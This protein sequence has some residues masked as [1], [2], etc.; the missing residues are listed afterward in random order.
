MKTPEQ[1]I[2]ELENKI[3][4]LRKQKQLKELESA[5]ANLSQEVKDFLKEL[6][7]Q[8]EFDL[9]ERHYK[10]NVSG[11]DFYV[12]VEKS[13]S[14]FTFAITSYFLIDLEDDI[15]DQKTLKTTSVSKIREFI[16]DN[17]FEKVKFDFK[18]TKFWITSK[19]MRDLK[20]TLRPT[21]F[22]FSIE[23]LRT[24]G[25]GDW[26]DYTS[27]IEFVKEITLTRFNEDG[28]VKEVEQYN[29]DG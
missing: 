15:C 28:S 1:E 8:W 9:E 29:A 4:E 2:K 19:Q 16:K 11:T 3:E 13:K 18:G 12:V 27:R 17:I 22:G 21:P 10:K 26:G 14:R 7:T 25:L 24:E 23:D 20:E 6:D 5:E